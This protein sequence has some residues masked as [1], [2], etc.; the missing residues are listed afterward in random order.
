MSDE[1]KNSLEQLNTEEI[2]KKVSHSML[3]RDAHF[4]ALG[5]LKARGVNIDDLPKEP[6]ENSSVFN[7]KKKYKHYKREM[8]E[9][10][11]V[12]GRILQDAE[13]LAIQALIQEMPTKVDSNL[14]PEA[15]FDGGIKDKILI[16]TRWHVV[17]LA[18]NYATTF[19]FQKYEFHWIDGLVYYAI[20]VAIGAGGA[21]L[22][23]IFFTRFA[24]T[25]FISL[26]IQIALVTST[27]L[28]LST[29]HSCRTG[30]C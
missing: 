23:F 13:V 19:V 10:L 15:I 26:H 29:W 20:S 18:I 1:L 8:L 6:D 9:S 22:I 30:I 16:A 7:Y 24:K 3:T 5:I 12:S 28:L 17:I 25:R 14:T 21:L 27:L 11:L 2:L 4:A